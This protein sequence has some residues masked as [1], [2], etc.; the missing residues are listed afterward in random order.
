[1]AKPVLLTGFVICLLL[2]ACDRLFFYPEKQLQ[3][4]PAALGLP[5]EDVSFPSTDGT[6][7]HGWF[8]PARGKAK[9]TIVFMH[10]NAENISTHFGAV[11]WLPAH[12]F[13]VFVWDYRGFGHSE[14]QPDI[15]GVHRDAR[16]ALQYVI[17]RPDVDPGKIVLFGQS[18]GA[19]IALHTAATTSHPLL[20][21]VAES[22]FSRY[23]AIMREK[24]AASLITW[25]FQWTTVFLT[26]GYDPLD[27]VRRIH[28]PL[29]LIHG[30][31]DRVVPLHHAQELYDNANPPKQLWIIESGGHIGAF[32]PEHQAYR[33]RLVAFLETL[34]SLHRQ[35]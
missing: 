3:R 31:H 35:P 21:V 11:Y 12:G 8:L 33:K 19:A 4:T 32:T 20:A 13:N 9:A 34:A 18:I 25:P 5:Y 7:L 30:D 24:M 15:E 6:M 29:L 17:G 27:A 14:G 23:S 28:I 16:A 26:R 10:G 1:M 2:T 22:A